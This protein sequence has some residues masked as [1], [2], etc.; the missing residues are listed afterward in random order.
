MRSRPVELDPLVS[1]W[2]VG[3]DQAYCFARQLGPALQAGEEGI[4]TQLPIC[5]ARCLFQ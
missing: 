1:D 5:G 4:E 3:V 2:R